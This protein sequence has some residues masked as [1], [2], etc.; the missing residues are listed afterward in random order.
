MKPLEKKGR[1]QILT[2]RALFLLGKLCT[3]IWP[4]LPKLTAVISREERKESLPPPRAVVCKKTKGIQFYSSI[5]L[6]REAL[7]YLEP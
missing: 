6:S 1:R 7:K 3:I 2:P 5:N 4:L